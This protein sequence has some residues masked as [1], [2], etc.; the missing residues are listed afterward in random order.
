MD[1]CRTYS[2]TPEQAGKLKTSF[3]TIHKLATEMSNFIFWYA[4]FKDTK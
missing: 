3:V 1:L 2:I 4:N